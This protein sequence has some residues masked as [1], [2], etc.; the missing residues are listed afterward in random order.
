MGKSSQEKIGL[1]EKL[2]SKGTSYR[3]IQKE[4]IKKFGSGMSNTT[5]KN[6]QRSQSRVKILEEKIEFLEDELALFKKLYFQLRKAIK[7]QRMGEF[8]LTE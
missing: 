3:L 4:L 8:S 1:A 5:L 2:L 6:L 7:K